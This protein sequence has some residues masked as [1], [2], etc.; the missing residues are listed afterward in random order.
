MKITA[1]EYTL[2]DTVYVL[3]PMYVRNADSLGK[4]WKVVAMAA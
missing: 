4:Y 1:L 2:P 3:L